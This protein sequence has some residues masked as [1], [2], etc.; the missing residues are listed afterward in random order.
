M[1]SQRESGFKRFLRVLG[2]IGLVLLLLASAGG[3]YL[4]VMHGQASIEGYESPL[5]AQ[6]KSGGQP[7][8][9]LVPQIVFVVIDGL[10]YDAVVDMPTLSLLQR[11]GAVARALAHMP[12]Y[13]Q[14]TWTTLVSGAW[15][16]VNGAALLNAPDDAIQP[17]AV[18][19]IFAAAKRTGLTTALAGA[20]W[21]AKMIPQDML[22]AHFFTDSFRAD[23]D[24]QSADA[25]LRFINNFHPNL[26]L[27]YFGDV[28][29]T[30]HE[31]GAESLAYRESAA[32]VD[33]HLRDILESIDLRH[34]VLII[35]ADHGHVDRGGHG[36]GDASV[37]YTPFVAVGEPI[38]PGNYGTIDEADIAPTIAAILGTPVPR[39]SQGVV[40]FDML[41]TDPAKR[42][43]VELDVAQQRREFAALYLASIGRGPLSDTADGD[44]DVALSSME[45]GNLESAYGLARIAVDRIDQEM[46]QARQR[47]IQAEQRLR[48]P[49]AVVAVLV[50]LMILA[51]RGGRRGRWL[52]LAALATQLVYNGLFLRQGGLYSFSGLSSLDEFLVQTAQRVAL[53]SVV[54][55]VIVLWRLIREREGSVLG[56]IRTSLGYSLLV[57]YLLGCQ[58]AMAYYLNGFRWSWYVPDM[59]IAFL[60]ISALVQAIMTAGVGVILPV[61]LLVS[62]LAYQG[63]RTLRRRARPA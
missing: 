27:I 5:R 4:W 44:V 54:G 32:R 46:A 43:E 60:Q 20:S 63:V 38:V 16:E 3:A 10:R 45:V 56:V 52:L 61:V 62:G 39:L 1:T 55:A 26:T 8:M 23:G 58:A 13:S 19:H 18:D 22:D 28:D 33:D 11:Q 59:G 57:I 30:A 49:V 6:P 41:R 42:A 12:S 34:T 21:W 53:A 37:V 36:G 25:G 50:P 9:P 17:I 15:P 29:E 35:T 47:R 40:R 51:L 31:A 7:T 24:Q 2:T 14:P 48:L